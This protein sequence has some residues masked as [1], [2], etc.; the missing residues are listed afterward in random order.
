MWT[1]TCD[2]PFSESFNFLNG[3]RKCLA[4]RAEVT[5]R[6]APVDDDPCSL[7]NE[8][9]SRVNTLVTAQDQVLLAQP[10]LDRFISPVHPLH[11]IAFDAVN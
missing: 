11:S 1:P 5:R 6:N 10:K 8:L 7:L 9:G 3:L 4:R 2:G